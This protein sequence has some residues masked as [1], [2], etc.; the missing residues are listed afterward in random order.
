MTMQEFITYQ[1]QTFDAYFKKLI[2]NEAIDAHAELD[3]Q[4]DREIS[5]S[6]LPLDNLSQ[7]AVEDAYDLET[8]TFSVLDQDVDVRSYLL[9]H[10]LAS[11]PPHRR[12]LILMS[13]F[14]DMTEPQ[15][16]QALNLK[17]ST[18]NYRKNN[19]LCRLRQIL[20]VLDNEE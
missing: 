10:L 20:E 7:F 6:E 9:G 14:L 2:R 5:F 4:A 18:V 12:N 19:A 3:T 8:M 17:T 11:L 15:I 13:Y 1:K 16:G